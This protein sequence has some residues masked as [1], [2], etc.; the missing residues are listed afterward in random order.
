MGTAFWGLCRWQ[1]MDYLKVPGRPTQNSLWSADDPRRVSE[2]P[3]LLVPPSE[4]FL[5]LAEE[6]VADTVPIAATAVP[7]PSWWSCAGTLAAAFPLAVVAVGALAAGLFVAAGRPVARWYVGLFAG[8]VML[9]LGMMWVAFSWW[10]R[11]FVQRAAAG[12]RIALTASDVEEFNALLTGDCCLAFVLGLIHTEA[13]GGSAKGAADPLDFVQEELDGMLHSPKGLVVVNTTG[14]ILWANPS[15]C[16]Y[17]GYERTQ[18]LQENV[19]ILMPHPYAGQHDHF[20]RRHLRSGVRSVVGGSREVPV[21]RR[22]GTQG[23]A[24]LSLDDRIDM[25]DSDNRLFFGTFDFGHGEP[26]FEAVKA[27]LGTGP[28]PDISAFLALDHAA[29]SMVAINARGTVLYCNEATT[30]LFRWERAELVGKN[31]KVLMSEP[32]ASAHDGFLRSFVERDERCRRLGHPHVSGIVGSGRDVMAR[33]KSGQRVRVFLMVHRADMKSGE[34]A[35]CVFLAKM[36]HIGATD[37][38]TSRRSGS[39][40]RASASISSPTALQ[41]RALAKWTPL[42]PM[43]ARKCTLVLFQVRML[44]LHAE[45]DD[46]EMLTSW[47]EP[48]LILVSQACAHHHGLPQWVAGSHLAVLFNCSGAPNASHRSSAAAFMLQMSESTGNSSMADALEVA[49]SAVSVDVYGAKWEA[50]EVLSGDTFDLAT[51]LLRVQQDFQVKNPVI[52]STL[53]EEVQFSY[54]CRLVNRLVVHPGSAQDRVVEVFELLSLKAVEE[55]EWMY[56]LRSEESKPSPWAHWQQAWAHLPAPLASSSP[57]SLKGRLSQPCSPSNAR[58]ALREHLAQWPQ[59]A[60]GQSLLAALQDAVW[61]DGQE[62]VARC[63]AMPYRLQCWAAAAEDTVAVG[64]V[65]NLSFSG[66]SPKHA[67][68]FEIKVID[69]S[70]DEV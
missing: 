53:H 23:I 54:H 2:A 5:Q 41:S 46:P 31:V 34:A 40:M 22:D 30:Q 4:A 52:D 61:S 44:N 7:L 1:A 70:D 17:F 33:D 59:D 63:G 48:L 32:F 21:A 6:E 9:G 45:V 3:S 19:R 14:V 62:Q 25:R 38:A 56:Q 12:L 36:V 66:S 27:G 67:D 39:M 11:R 68:Q 35:D 42:P 28:V 37:V 26:L 65:F 43:R 57:A 8:L 64:S 13:S 20:I 60:V 10:L 29:E 50:Q 24:L 51:A 69:A 18:L 47:F 16:H 49:I 55:D 15:L 58:T